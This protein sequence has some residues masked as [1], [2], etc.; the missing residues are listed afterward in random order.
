[1]KL[2]HKHQNEKTYINTN[3]HPP[4]HI[5]V[6]P[7]SYYPPSHSNADCL[8]LKLTHTQHSMSSNLL[9]F[10]SHF[11]SHQEDKIYF[12]SLPIHNLRSRTITG[13]VSHSIM[14]AT[15]KMFWVFNN[16]KML[17]NRNL[18]IQLTGRGFSKLGDVACLWSVC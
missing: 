2:V 11:V 1:M 3:L 7:V 10:L 14:V 17:K 15:H 8:Y 5:S 16:K 4:N 12:P 13:K 6:A 9:H 18:K